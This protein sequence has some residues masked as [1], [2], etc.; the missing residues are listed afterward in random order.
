MRYSPTVTE[1]LKRMSL[2]LVLIL[3]LFF[4]TVIW[5]SSPKEQ[6]QPSW[7]GVPLQKR[8][9]YDSHAYD[10]FTCT[11]FD[12]QRIK[13][14]WSAVNDDYCDCADGTDEPGTSACAN[15]V[16]ACINEGYLPSS[17]PSSRVND[18]VCE[19]E[20]C[21][22]SDE[23]ASGVKCPNVCAKL[24]SE[25]AKEQEERE[26]RLAASKQVLRQHQVKVTEVLESFKN[27]EMSLAPELERLKAELDVA[28][29]NLNT[30]SEQERVER[31]RLEAEQRNSKQV[32]FREADFKQTRQELSETYESIVEELNGVIESVTELK[33]SLNLFSGDME[34]LGKDPEF[35][36]TDRVKALLQSWLNVQKALQDTHI[37]KP[38]ETTADGRV[39]GLFDS[40]D[41]FVSYSHSVDDLGLRSNV[42]FSDFQ[43]TV[44]GGVCGD[45]SNSL[46]DCVY[47]L[48]HSAWY[49]VSELVVSAYQHPIWNRLYE[50]VVG[51]SSNASVSA[52][53]P[54]T[55]ESVDIAAKLRLARESVDELDASIKDVESQLAPVEDLKTKDFGPGKLWYAVKGECVQY[56]NGEYV[57]KVCFHEG[58]TQTSN[59]DSRSTRL[60]TFERFGKRRD[61]HDSTYKYL[62]YTNGDQCWNGPK[63]SVQVHLQ[64]GPETKILS[65]SE[66]SKCEYEMELESPFGCDY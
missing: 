30:L 8:P 57:Y 37:S 5:A 51:K 17:I 65:I 41:D 43:A 52:P 19:P 16:F 44:L 64:C 39:P 2:T 26:R 21:D 54:V 13:L 20:C 34:V 29:T 56:D 11:G 50:S 27:R 25:H 60:G 22:G 12:Q 48:P 3:S 4:N 42:T 31:E 61:A 35:G 33:A 53:E 58:A 24:A 47:S 36:K 15:G 49:A 55:T 45:E 62:L 66:P 7:L 23:Y 28:R 14:P 38:I 59:I 32:C 10:T 40:L 63:R 46:L 6:L 1:E 18:G 9:L